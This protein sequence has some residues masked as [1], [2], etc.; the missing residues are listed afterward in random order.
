[1][2]KLVM[3]ILMLPLVAMAQEVDSQLLT[4]TEFTVKQGHAAQFLEGVKKWKT[5]YNENNGTNSWNFWSRVQGEGNVY[6]VSGNMSNWAE[7]DNDDEAGEAC[8]VVAMN[9]IMPHVEKVVYDITRSI[10][11]WSKKNPSTD[12]KL[13]WVTYFKVKDRAMFNEI[14]KDVSGTLADEEGEP[15]GYWYGFMGGG[16][17]APDYMVSETFP[18]YAAL[19]EDDKKDSPFTVYKKVHGDKKAKEMNEMW[20]KAVDKGWSYLWELNQDLSN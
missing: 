19:D 1:M 4:L 5:C 3:I 16:L 17:D 12:M 13:V 18:S 11:K 8:R 2:K 6:G 9:F 14:V 20:S 7:M 15:R 10:P